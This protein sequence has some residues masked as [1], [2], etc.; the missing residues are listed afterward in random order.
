M[1]IVGN[2]SRFS[3]RMTI[4]WLS[5]DRVATSFSDKP[6]RRRSSRIDPISRSIVA[7]RWRSLSLDTDA[8]Y[9]TSPL[10]R[11]VTIGTIGAILCQTCYL[12]FKMSA[13]RS[14]KSR[15]TP[16]D[17]INS[18]AKQG[19]G[20]GSGA[21]VDAR[22]RTFC[23]LRRIEAIAGL[24]HATDGRLG[25]EALAEGVVAEV[26]WLIIEQI[27]SIRD[28]LAVALR[29]TGPSKI[30]SR[31]MPS[32]VKHPLPRRGTCGKTDG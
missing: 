28:D 14:S 16:H 20:A 17:S 23:S 4:V 10:T 7:S 12:H 19:L 3:T 24:L 27:L 5:P 6:W 11:D 8:F 13:N 31:A 25:A 26:G 2:R 30:G 18:S 21:A 22:D 9:R 1:S 15:R 29:F 32:G